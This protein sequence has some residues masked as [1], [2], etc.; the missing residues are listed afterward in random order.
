MD[1]KDIESVAEIRRQIFIN[2]YSGGMAHFASCFSAVEIIYT[3]YAKGVLRFDPQN[4]DMP[5]RDRFVLSKGHGALALYTVM[6]MV[7]YFGKEELF[8]YLKPYCHI[9]GEP[10]MRDLKGI[11]ATTGSLGHGL[12]VAVGMAMAQ[13]LDNNNAKTYVLLGDGESQEG[14]V[15]EAAMSATTFELDNLVVI[16]DYNEIQKTRRVDEIVKGVDWDKKWTSFGWNIMEVD[17]HDVDALERAFKSVPQNTK[18]T[19]I[20]A[21]T[22]KGKGVSLMENNPVWHFKIPNKKEKKVFMEELGISES[23]M[24][25]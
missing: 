11:E 3:L 1:Y 10:N 16:L 22:I 2:G 24:E 20:L 7:G 15:W 17:G 23:E 5:E 8:S 12:S 14:I 18:P 21:H 9:G 13:K 25:I 19:I 6:S 4:C